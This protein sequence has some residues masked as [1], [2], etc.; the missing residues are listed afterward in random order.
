LLTALSQKT[1]QTDVEKALKKSGEIKTV[2]VETTAM[3]K[4]ELNELRTS[5]QN[6]TTQPQPDQ[7]NTPG[8][9]SIGSEN[10]NCET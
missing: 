4:T 1:L 5:L 9:A 8:R 10:V 3:S 2:T 6:R 7:S